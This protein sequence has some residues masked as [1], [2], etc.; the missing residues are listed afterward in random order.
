[1]NHKSP[2]V[3]LSTTGKFHTFSLARQLK[4][5]DMLVCVYTSYPQLKLK[6][7]QLEKNEI[8]T[9]PEMRLLQHAVS[10]IQFLKTKFDKN[11]A[12]LNRKLLEKYIYKTIPPCDV[13][14]GL[15]GHCYEVGKKIKKDGG[16]Y[17]CDRGSSHIRYQNN[18]LREEYIK[19]G[20]PFAGID[21][22]VIEAEEKEYELA[23]VITV[24]SFFVFN[25][26][27][28]QGVPEAKLRLVAYG[29]DTKLF[30][31]MDNQPLDQFIVT[32]VGGVSFRKGI[33]YL[34]AAFEQLTHP[35]KILNII[36]SAGDAQH[37]IEE[38]A[39][40]NKNV[41]IFGHVKQE[42]LKTIYSQSSV[43]CLASIEE[44]LSMVM[45]EA[46]ACGCPV[47]AT[48]NTG[49]ANLFDDGVEGFIT[50]IRSPEVMAEK[51]QLLA[52]KP[53]LAASMSQAALHKVQALGGWDS[54]GEAY[55][56]VIKELVQ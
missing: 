54:Y 46:M 19:Q 29:V 51:M 38:Y 39:A 27:L 5:R 20:E 7:E 17:I 43:F 25:S 56:K 53:A 24:P 48:V 44:G 4:K 13:Y 36:G 55:C 9:R 3:V 16:I 33:P 1:M 8:R 6:N 35:A 42:Q 28:L 49:A 30:H 11:L 32:Y 10:K 52:D 14:I 31:P 12:W 45:A 2:Q 15:S 22:R 18:I 41:N 23:D 34:I 21:P 26:F 50:P 37:L 47:I 40:I